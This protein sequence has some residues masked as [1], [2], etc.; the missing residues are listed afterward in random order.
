[1]VV[2]F[3]RVTFPVKTFAP[4]QVLES[5]S[6]VDDAVVPLKQVLLMRRQ[7]PVREM[8]FANV[9]VAAVPVMLR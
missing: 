6:N 3:V 5:E 2:A 9:L 4:V 7:P 8:P 1:M